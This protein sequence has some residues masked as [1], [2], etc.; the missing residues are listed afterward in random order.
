MTDWYSPDPMYKKMHGIQ[1]SHCSFWNKVTEKECWFCGSKDS[2]IVRRID[3]FRYYQ[4]LEQPD[5]YERF[6]DEPEADVE[7]VLRIWKMEVML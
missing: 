7:N 6:K 3:T 4:Y 2:W 5:W 1:C